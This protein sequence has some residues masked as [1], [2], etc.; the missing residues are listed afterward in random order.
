MADMEALFSSM[1][2]SRY[3]RAVPA[4]NR[5]HSGNACRNADAWA[6]RSHM[7]VEV[8]SRKSYVFR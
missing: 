7:T 5:S 4:T 2:A 3:V 6:S 1:A 8:C